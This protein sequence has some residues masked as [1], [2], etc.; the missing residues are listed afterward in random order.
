MNEWYLYAK[1]LHIIFIVTWFAALFYVVRLFIYQTEA[2][3]AS[4]IEVS[5]QLKLM[6][7]RLWYIIGWPSAVLALV[8]GLTMIAPWWKTDWMKVKVGCVAILLL[9]HLYCHRLFLQLQKDTYKLSSTKLRMLNEVP[10]L[11][12][13]I[14]VFLAVWKSISGLWIGSIAVLGTA[15]LILT[16][17]K[18]GRRSG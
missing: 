8:F 15:L 5:E 11:L 6:A 17:I 10:T 18:V 14:I 16:L 4:K 7:H 13:F 1:A 2:Y 9:Y 12:L 3:A